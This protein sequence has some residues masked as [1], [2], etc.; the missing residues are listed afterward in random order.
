MKLVEVFK[1]SRK[2]DTYLYVERGTDWD[3]L[4]EGL[5]QIFGE[6]EPVLSLKLTPERQMARYSGREVLDALAQQGYLLQ[7]PPKDPV[8]PTC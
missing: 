7:L 3:S 5:R 6:P 2:A 8:E 4:P 1:S